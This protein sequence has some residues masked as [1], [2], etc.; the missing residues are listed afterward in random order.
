[1]AGARERCGFLNNKLLWHVPFSFRR[2]SPCIRNNQKTA[3]CSDSTTEV[4]Q[5][6][7]L[8]FY[9]LRSF[10]SIPC[11]T[12]AKRYQEKPEGAPFLIFIH[13]R[14]TTFRLLLH[15]PS[16]SF[17]NGRRWTQPSGALASFK[18]S[19]LRCV[20]MRLPHPFSLFV[21]QAR[22]CCITLYFAI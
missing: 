21:F 1:M 2:L 6:Q 10:L 20:C 12:W 18:V 13:I 4:G 15:L 7:T 11:P 17:C 14:L 3:Y 5:H 19:E 16:F 8:R 22:L 9:S